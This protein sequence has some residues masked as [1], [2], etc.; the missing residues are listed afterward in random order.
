MN[1]IDELL[2]YCP[3]W[4]PIEQKTSENNLIRPVETLFLCSSEQ[5]AEQLRLANFQNI[6]MMDME[7]SEKLQLDQLERHIIA[8]Q[9]IYIVDLLNWLD[10]N[11]PYHRKDGNK[12]IETYFYLFKKLTK[13]D[14]PLTYCFIYSPHEELSGLVEGLTLS[15]KK[16]IAL[17]ETFSL[18]ATSL[19]ELDVYGL[20]EAYEREKNTFLHKEKDNIQKCVLSPLQDVHTSTL[21]KTLR[22][23]RNYVITGNGKIAK[24]LSNYL[25]KTYD[26]RIIILGRRE[27]TPQDSQELKS[28]GVSSYI[29]IDLGKLE[30][31]KDAW[32]YLQREYG[33]INGIFH[34]AGCLDD[35]LFSNK[36]FDGF[37]NV[38][39]PKVLC[40]QNLDAVSAETSLDFFACFSSL[41]G[42]IGNIGQSDYA[43][44]NA[45]LR[46]WTQKRNIQVS[47]NKRHGKTICIDWGLW[48]AGG[49]K[50][51]FEQNDL[52]PMNAD[53]AFFA[54]EKVFNAN[55]SH[56]LIFKGNSNVLLPFTA[57]EA[58]EPI[59]T[60]TTITADQPQIMEQ[61]IRWVKDAVVKFTKLNNLDIN[62]SILS[63]GVDSVATI[64]IITDIERDLRKIKEDT[65]YPSLFG[66]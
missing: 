44:A 6:F 42:F 60:S 41:T 56:A 15:L 64:N 62:D 66:S 31:L 48:E 55:E 36:D 46:H 34:L 53:E 18:Q 50:I 5:V 24:L 14:N 12:Y 65:H 17:F 47:E 45:F 16:E 59:L 19:K 1:K 27:L 28:A 3:R 63:Q 13:I 8:S 23:S 7:L 20:F 9:S 54:M 61:V 32:S 33:S 49:M 4:D 29:K 25:T 26:S 40:T 43:A 38:L 58:V 2:I 11:E 51:P 21:R 35:K 10:F 39:Y 57:I 37:L 30:K 22:P 52:L